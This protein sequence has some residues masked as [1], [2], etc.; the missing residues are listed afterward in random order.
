M[1][2][3]KRL[4][5][6]TAHKFV[7]HG[8]LYAL[9]LLS[10]FCLG[11]PAAAQFTSL[12]SASPS[13][14]AAATPTPA[15]EPTPIPLAE[16]VPEAE[17]ASVTLRDIE[18]D[19][20][21]SDATTA[22]GSDLPVLV[23]E[24]DARETETQ[25]ILRSRPSL[26]T[27]QTLESE[28][29]KLGVKL[30][31]WSSDL[32]VRATQLQSYRTRL[33]SLDVVWQ[34][35][36][37]ASSASGA[38]PEVIQ[39]I[40]TVIDNIS[41]LRDTVQRRQA[42][43]FQLQ[44][45]VIEQ[46]AH[47][48]NAGDQ[49][50][51]AREAAVTRLFERDSPPIWSKEVLGRGRQI[52]AQEGQSSFQ[53]QFVLLR[54]Y[55]SREPLRFLLHA[56]I[57]FLLLVVLRWVRARIRPWVEHEPEIK[58]VAPVLGVPAAAAGVLSLFL[59]PWIY[60]Q[61]PRP[62]WAILGALA[63]F[64][65][66][67]I[68]HQLVARQ[69]FPIINA[70]VVFYFLD[71]LRIISASLPTVSRLLFLVEMLGGIIFLAWLSRR[72]RPANDSAEERGRFW[73]VL[74]TVARIGL[75]VF[76]VAIFANAFGYVGLANLLG[77]GFLRSAYVAVIIYSLTRILDGLIMFAL[78]VRPLS[79]LRMVREH[80]TLIWD[81]V[82]RVVWW[83]ATLLWLLI[84]L[85][86]FSLR[87]PLIQNIRNILN[88]SLTV[89]SISLS[90]GGVIAFGITI[91]ASFLLSRFVR[92][93]LDED[94]YPHLELARG[95]PY[96]IST[97]LHYLILIIGFLVATAALGFDMTKFTILAGAF[98]VGLGF[99]LQNIVNNF[100]SGLILLFERPVQVGD[101]IQL[102]DATGVVKRIGIRA[103]VIRTAA[104][105]D[106]IVPN[107]SLISER[108]TNWT[109]SDRKRGFEIPV[110]VG[111]DT[112]P[113]RVL[114]LL[115]GVAEGHPLVSTNP[116]PLPLFLGFGADSLNFELRVST[117]QADQ[118]LKVKSDLAIN[119]NAA[120]QK[121]NITI[122]NAQRDIHLKSVSQETLKALL[123]RN[124]TEQKGT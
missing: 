1:P 75:V 87:T 42:E 74:R 34:K 119:I 91:W 114:E 69:L 30:P 2:A 67:F 117:D 65:A 84:T 18:S 14:T 37:Q 3:I 44:N 118:W 92:F 94:I 12:P 63:L 56:F 16:V 27:L 43:I 81:K 72:K 32:T 38:P 9:I 70:L 122:P 59:S 52:L 96:A 60:P 45:S 123:D 20:T 107:G 25:K 115:K 104:G 116:A 108:V 51:Q 54:N 100:V 13:P 73:K 93:L 71:Q 99:G 11:S 47:V 46:V 101:T 62:L 22:I 106:L 53:T 15:G 61:A 82:R 8:C 98:G 97:L 79:L 40:Q 111:Y 105:A 88:A 36:L 41:R 10:F 17:S 35:T 23:R 50:T 58:R 124:A 102:G 89:G 83:L 21:S 85:E 31:Q 6:Y 113:K 86:I 7:F 26:D 28:W 76:A 68:L 103:S 78:R 110:G 112:D 57:F 19:L 39:Q 48:S 66:A 120:L 5:F 33:N 64:P 4:S 29:Q 109:F 95:L 55:V 80:R 90:L 49:I 77:N 24:I 121:E